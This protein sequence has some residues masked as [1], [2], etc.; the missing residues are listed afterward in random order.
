MHENFP[1]SNNDRLDDDSVGRAQPTIAEKMRDFA[2]KKRL[3]ARL[4]QIILMRQRDGL[5]DRTRKLIRKTSNDIQCGRLENSSEV[6]HEIIEYYLKKEDATSAS[7]FHFHSYYYEVPPREL[8]ADDDGFQRIIRDMSSTKEDG[9]YDCRYEIGAEHL[10]AILADPNRK[11]I[12]QE[13]IVDTGWLGKFIDDNFASLKGDSS[14]DDSFDEKTLATL[15]ACKKF[16]NVKFL[17][18]RRDNGIRPGMGE[19]IKVCATLLSTE[20]VDEIYL[21]EL[22][23]EKKEQMFGWQKDNVEAIISSGLTS[24]G[25][26]AEIELWASYSDRLGKNAISFFDDGCLI[27]KNWH[28]VQYFPDMELPEIDQVWLKTFDFSN[29]TTKKRFFDKTELLT[30][31]I[32]NENY[33]DISGFCETVDLLGVEGVKALAKGDEN[34]IAVLVCGAAMKYGIN[35]EKIKGILD[36]NSELV[37]RMARDGVFAKELG[38]LTPRL[39]KDCDC[40]I[41]ITGKIEQIIQKNRVGMDVRLD[42]FD[43]FGNF[44]PDYIVDMFN[45][46]AYILDMAS[47]EELASALSRR[48]MAILENLKAYSSGRILSKC[49]MLE[50]EGG[51]YFDENGE[52]TPRFWRESI[53]CEDFDFVVKQGPSKI[54]EDPEIAEALPIVCELADVN[55]VDNDNILMALAVFMHQDAED[56]ER[57]SEN[58]KKIRELFQDGSAKDM[59]LKSLRGYYEKYLNSDNE[60]FPL[61]LLV[62]NHK[63]TKYD[64]AGPLVQIESF[65]R[66]TT[67]LAKY[68]DLKAVTAEFEKKVQGHRWTNEEKSN[69]YNVSTELI[70][71]D[72]EIYGE[73]VELF[74]NI[75]DKKDFDKFTKEIYPLYRAKLTLLKKY[76][77]HGDGIGHGTVSSNY[78]GIDKEALKNQLHNALLP[79]NLKELSSDKRQGGIEIVRA[80]IFKEITDLFQTKFGIKKEVISEDFSKRD[81]R[82]IEDMTLYLSNMHAASESKTNLVGYYLALQ[83]RQTDDASDW[84]RLRQGAACSPADYLEDDK[85]STVIEAQRVSRENSPLTSSNIGV[86]EERLMDFCAE[87]QADTENIR[88]GNIQTVDLRLQNLIT[89]IDELKDP[90]LYPDSIDKAKIAILDKY[91][92]KVIGSVS[93]KM[94]QVASGRSLKMNDEE[95]VIADELKDLLSSN[96]I[97]LTPENIKKYLQDGFTVLKLPFAIS[98]KVIESGASEAIGQLQSSLIPPKDIQDIFDRLG[99][100]FKPQSGVVAISQDIDYLE[101]LIVKREDQLKPDEKKRAIDYLADIREQIASLDQIYANI[102]ASYEKVSKSIHD[103]SNENSAVVSKIQEIDRIIHGS[104]S[105]SVITTVCTKDL[106]KISENMRACLSMKTGGCNNDTDLTFGE[107]YKFYLYSHNAS[108]AEGSISDEIVYFVPSW[109]DF[110]ERRMSFVMDRIYGQR[111]RDILMSHVATMLKK[112]KDLREKFA[113]AKI[114]IIVPYECMGSCGCNMAAMELEELMGDQLP[115]AVDFAKK[116]TTIPKSGYGDHYV[117]FGT[118]GGARVPGDRMISSGIEIII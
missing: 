57:A 22:E 110:G 53:I 4:N 18:R 63:N 115:A 59:A 7:E 82:A 99:E 118:G 85:A 92:V 37:D 34:M 84:D 40:K 79:F 75:V 74:N 116:N 20:D 42:N 107:G 19:Q 93:A 94:W 106:L 56:W 41:G 26:N 2:R 80:Q 104:G 28:D 114:S 45:Q 36:D 67:E 55:H 14:Y 3:G 9:S 25:K 8:V 88:L 103:S 35:E 29:L 38:F 111:N 52:L 66:F 58:D 51:P 6:W 62:M 91:P 16:D 76:D 113:D 21:A 50:L 71:A 23:S 39:F 13:K 54:M 68:P 72:P 15:S 27:F 70:Q 108:D 24:S 117:E 89:N 105:E 86:N 73:F 90:D 17:D 1:A 96:G 33:Y 97:E 83:L 49:S 109:D 112:A 5:G 30:P 69:F 60:E 32:G 101:N 48:Q 43:D 87:L 46:R 77:Y 31:A 81:T 98:D 47:K 11:K 78:E 65:L 61:A 44:T 10:E 64:G 95:S 12:F 102:I 100:G